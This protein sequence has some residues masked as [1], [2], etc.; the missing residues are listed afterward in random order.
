M[1]EEKGKSLVALPVDYVVVDTETTGLSSGRSHIIELSALRVRN[2]EVTEVFSS[3]L[4]PPKQEICEFGEVRYAYADSFITGLTGITNEML[5]DAPGP[6]EILPKAH[7]FLEDR[8]LLGHNVQ[9]DVNFLYDAFEQ[10][11]GR[12]LRNDFLDTLRLSRKLLPE[13]PHHRLSDLA[14]ALGVRYEGA[15]RAEADCRITHGCYLK[16]RELALERFSEEEFIRLFPRK[17]MEYRARDIGTDRK[18][19]DE[20]HPLYGKRV[21]FAGE[22]S[23]PRKE[24]MQLVADAGGVNCDSVGS[25]TDYLVVGSTA[26]PAKENAVPLQKG[27]GMAVLTEQAFFRL[28][29][30]R[31]EGLP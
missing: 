22:L 9:F 21:A 17:K 29:R 11:L 6:E 24:A 12:P 10:W 26:L 4:R 19:F 30:N 23:I 2:G 28:V 7:A 27:H 20:T 8:V 15:H 3:L 18:N 13:L 1:R 5:E 16:L 25:R 14:A 31:E